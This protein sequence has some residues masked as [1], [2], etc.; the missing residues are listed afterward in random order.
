VQPGGVQV[1]EQERQQQA[2]RNPAVE[3]FPLADMRRRDERAAALHGRLIIKRKGNSRLWGV[4]SFK[5]V[6]FRPSYFKVLFADGSV[7]DGLSHRMVTA[8][9]AYS[10]QLPERQPPAGVNVPQVEQ[11][12][13]L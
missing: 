10:L 9:K 12:Q 8:G 7:E 2:G 11:V 1:A 6:A 5:G 3:L 13:V 4:A